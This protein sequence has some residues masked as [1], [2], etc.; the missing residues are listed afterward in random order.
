MP[1]RDRF[2]WM[3][4]LLGLK[5]SGRHRGFVTAPVVA[6]SSGTPLPL[7]PFDADPGPL[8][9]PYFLAYERRTFAYALPEPPP[10]PRM[11]WAG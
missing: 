5:P 6:R 7:P 10:D 9:R 2:T 11:R 4:R 1:L 3:L 8:V